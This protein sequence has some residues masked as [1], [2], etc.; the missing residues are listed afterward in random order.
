MRRSASDRVPAPLTGSFAPSSYSD[1]ARLRP[2]PP[3]RPHLPLRSLLRVHA[4]LS[5][6][7]GPPLLVL[8]PGRRRARSESCWARDGRC[9]RAGG[10]STHGSGGSGGWAGGCGSACGDG[11]AGTGRE[12]TV[13]VPRSE[14]LPLSSGQQYLSALM[15]GRRRADRRSIYLLTRSGH[16]AR[17]RFQ[18]TLHLPLITNTH[19]HVHAH[20]ASSLPLPARPFHVHPSRVN[21]TPF[22]M[23]AHSMPMPTPMP[24]CGAVRAH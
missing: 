18:H 2:V 13:D 4:P 16:E 5:L 8:L 12:G 1:P 7:S 19:L 20:F 10:R 17:T 6:S 15:G 22:H 11:G 9:S 3:L 14:E 24:T 21:S 23:P